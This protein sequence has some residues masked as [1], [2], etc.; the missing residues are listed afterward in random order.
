LLE[1]GRSF[2]FLRKEDDDFF[3]FFSDFFRDYFIAKKLTSDF[4]RDL[5][6][7]FKRKTLKPQ[8]R[9]L[10][11]NLLAW[12]K[13]CQEK[14]E[15]WLVEE[16]DPVIL[17]NLLMLIDKA[18]F[19]N[20]QAKQCIR[21]I[22]GRED[23]KL[24]VGSKCRRVKQ[25]EDMVFIPEGEFIMGSYEKDDEY[26][27]RKLRLREFYID[28]YPVTNEKYQK[29]VKETGHRRPFHWKGGKIPEGLEKHPVVCVTWFDASAYAQWCGKRLPTEAEWE[30]ASRGLLGRRWPWGCEWNMSVLYSKS[31]RKETYPVGSFPEAV[32]P[33]RVFDMAGNVWEWCQDWY[34]RSYY[35]KG[36]SN[37]DSSEVRMGK[38]KVVKGGSFG[39]F[40]GNLRCANKYYFCPDDFNPRTGFRCCMDV[41]D[42]DKKT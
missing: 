34:D 36:V 1:N 27:P 21:R 5:R 30:K 6:I 38:Y 40:S 14:I 41:K 37:K 18:P 17:S 42:H 39:S 29:F 22:Y 23:K 11:I 12:D 7:N 10:M 2:S 24:M 19:L 33:Y 3:A 35:N 32:S 25:F 26:P 31:N 20:V 15:S 16:E 4:D 8:I 9:D 13:E 28:K